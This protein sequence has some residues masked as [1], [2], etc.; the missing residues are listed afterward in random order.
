MVEYKWEAQDSRFLALV[1]VDDFI[2]Q[3]EMALFG[4]EDMEDAYRQHGRGQ[5]IFCV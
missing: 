2:N 3:V 1:L 5:S 4:Y